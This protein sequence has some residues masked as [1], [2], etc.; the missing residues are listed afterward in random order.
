MKNIKPLS[1]TGKTIE[2]QYFPNLQ[3]YKVV[4]GETDFSFRVE[5]VNLPTEIEPYIFKQNYQRG[6]QQTDHKQRRGQFAQ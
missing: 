6:R 4:W 5:T 3:E 1:G 2:Y